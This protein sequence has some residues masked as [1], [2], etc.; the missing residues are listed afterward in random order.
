MNEVNRIQDLMAAGW[1][2]RIECKGKGRSYEMT[3]EA[4][5]TQVLQDS[6]TEKEKISCLMTQAFAV[7][8]TIDELLCKLEKQIAKKVQGE[9]IK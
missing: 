1:D 7:G 6:M 2:I 8:N 5:A 4:V 3:Y 9:K